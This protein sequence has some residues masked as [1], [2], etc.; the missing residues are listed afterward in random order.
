MNHGFPV[1]TWACA[2][3]R[4]AHSLAC[5]CDSSM[6]VS[7]SPSEA[8]TSS[9]PGPEQTWAFR[10][11]RLAS[12]LVMGTLPAPAPGAAGAQ[13]PL[14]Q[15]GGDPAQAPD[16]VSQSA[17]PSWRV[18]S[19]GRPVR[20]PRAPS[21]RCWGP[22]RCPSETR[23]FS[24]KGSQHCAS[25]SALSCDTCSLHVRPK[26]EL[27]EQTNTRSMR[28]DEAVTR[29]FSPLSFL[30]HLSW[31]DFHLV[32]VTCASRDSARP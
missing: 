28:S 29:V 8:V 17:V 25:L 26:G 11:P 23:L 1:V 18:C 10:A 21:E 20:G 12:G 19:P 4:V 6:C 24:G 31:G 9:G 15:S 7:W 5:R 30:S 27:G 2:G 3:S 13:D 22:R 14:V 16:T 32:T